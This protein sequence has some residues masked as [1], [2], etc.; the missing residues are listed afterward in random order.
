MAHCPCASSYPPSTNAFSRPFHAP[1][2]NAH[3]LALT[4]NPFWDSSG[5]GS[6]KNLAC[7]WVVQRFIRGWGVSWGLK[8]LHRG[9]KGASKVAQRLHWGPPPTLH[10]LQKMGTR[11]LL[12]Q[13]NGFCCCPAQHYPKERWEQ[14][15][16]PGHIWPK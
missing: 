1:Y 5:Q 10:C 3:P 2:H 6:K 9:F 16:F 14:P 8:A 15:F 11:T 13:G 4:P 12:L 7:S